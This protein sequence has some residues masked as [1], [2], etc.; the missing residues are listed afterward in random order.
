MH[1]EASNHC[2]ASCKDTDTSGSH[3]PRDDLPDLREV[4]EDLYDFRS[5]DKK[6]LVPRVHLKEPFVCVR[7]LV[8]ADRRGG[9]PDHGEF[10]QGAERW[11]LPDA[12]TRKHF[13]KR[14][15]CIRAILSAASTRF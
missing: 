13:E 12:P 11:G 15:A 4:L 14:P 5:G 3:V 9:R 7:E 8:A 6:A 1:T 10:G 2:I